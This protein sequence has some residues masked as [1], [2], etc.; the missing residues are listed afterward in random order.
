MLRIQFSMLMIALL[1]GATLSGCSKPQPAATGTP[2]AP[3]ATH[4]AAHSDVFRFRIGT[5]DAFALKDGDIDV[6]ND[7]KTF[8][9]GQPSDQ[10][11]ALLAAAGQPTDVLHLSIQPLL[12]R[13]GARILLFD[14]GAAGATFARAGR[15]P[16][17]LRAAGVQPSQVTDIFLSHRHPDHVGGLLTPEGAL[18]FPNATIHL[19]I[20]EWEA[21]KV[22]ADVA[23]LVS[24]ITPKVATF[25]PNAAILP[26]LVT[27][28]A[29]DGHT[30]GH[31]AYE[32][33]SGNE[34]LLYMGDAAHHYV[35]SVQ[36]PD[37]TVQY[38]QDAPLAQA[39]R[40]ALLQRAADENLH[41]Y[42]VHF[43]FPGLGHIKVQGDSFVWVPDR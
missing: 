33:A 19:S 32:I 37:W 8:G 25:Q 29:V 27:A 42:A 28:V 6:A 34:R 18:A 4:P 20:P 40:R 15:L 13:S 30:P 23:T 1:A 36:R 21:L 41:V 22:K 12:V 5:L 10:V 39:S 43:P 14:T 35:I 31:S 7:G 9:I 16:A 11:A 2:V 24:A 17:S 3:A 26:G 38:D